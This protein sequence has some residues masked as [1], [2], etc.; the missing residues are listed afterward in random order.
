MARARAAGAPPPLCVRAES[1]LE[2][3]S[4]RL[5]PTRAYP[6]RE[7][8]PPWSAAVGDAPPPAGLP[9]HV[10]LFDD[11]V[12]TTAHTPRRPGSPA[13][14]STSTSPSRPPAEA[15]P[16]SPPSERRS[17]RCGR[18]WRARGTGRRAGS[19]TPTLQLTGTSGSWLCSCVRRRRG[20]A[21][22]EEGG[23]R[24]EKDRGGATP[25]GWATAVAGGE[26][27]RLGAAGADQW[28]GQTGVERLLHDRLAAA[29]GAGRRH[30]CERGCSRCLKE[31]SALSVLLLCA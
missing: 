26:E 1:P 4:D 2:T 10:V 16:P 8:S 27:G 18:S 17:G 5:S 30:R 7:G 22:T 3:G 12:R 9:S 14:H 13:T 31:T 19:S 25:R 23:R 29:A 21:P 15:G 24:R 28:R 6:A 11:V 20:E